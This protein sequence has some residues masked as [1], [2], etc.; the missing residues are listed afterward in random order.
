LEI[1]DDQTTNAGTVSAFQR[2]VQAGN[3]TAIIGPIR[4]TEVQAITPYI[5]RQGIPVMMGGTAPKLTHEGDPWVFRT[6]PND[7]Y[8]AE[9]LSTFVASTLHLKKIA[10]FHS[11]DAFGAGGDAQL[12]T[13]LTAYHLTPVTDQGYNNHDADLTTQALAI[14]KSGADSLVSYCTYDEDCVLMA[15]TMHQLGVRVTWAGSPSLTSVT[16]RRLGGSLLYGTYGATDFAVGQNPVNAAFNKAYQAAY[17]VQA[18]IY[19]GYVYDALTILSMVMRK[20]GTTPSAIRTGILHL[21]GYTGV[22]GLYNFDQ[23]GDGL[24]QYTIVQNLKGSL[25]IIKVLHFESHHLQ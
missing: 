23:N 8:S 7:T 14:K 22:E 13:A 5:E 6:R 25:H 17:H 24:H 12:A 9:A 16:A 19:S 2:L 21:Q 3:I 4:S 20:S 15:R 10:V 1:V 18:D 11:T